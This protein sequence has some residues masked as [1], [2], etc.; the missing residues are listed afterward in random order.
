MSSLPLAVRIAAGL[1][2]TAVERARR[3]PQDLAEFPVTAVSRAMQVS[4]RMQQQLTDLAIKGDNA[5]ALLRTPA[6][7]P[8][9]AVFDEDDDTG[10]HATGT[11]GVYRLPAD[12]ASDDLAS[13]DLANAVQESVRDWYDAEYDQE[14]RPD[15]AD[16]LTD[17]AELTEDPTQDV[18]E[19]LTQDVAGVTA[20]L[21]EPAVDE[22]PAVLPSYGRLSLASVRG[23]LR[24]L[25]LD[26]LQALLD[27][28][29]AH[30]NRPE[31][32]RMLTNR[33][34]TVRNR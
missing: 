5:I 34:A 8:P 7:E 12:R 33:I 10:T 29:I 15:T 31:F 26:D 23:R 32:V 14:T 21:D 18:T 25:G 19:D 17:V 1:A 13:D 30:D 28:E 27:Y 4:M 3:L 22:V 11:A 2:A 9:W 6:E 24:S 16:D 20:V